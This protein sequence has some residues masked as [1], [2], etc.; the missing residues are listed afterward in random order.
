MPRRLLKP[1]KS[2]ECN[3]Q[4]PQARIRQTTADRPAVALTRENVRL[5]DDEHQN[6]SC[7][8]TK[9]R[10]P[11]RMSPL[12]RL[13]HRFSRPEI[14]PLESVQT[15]SVAFDRATFAAKHHQKGWLED[16]CCRELVPCFR[17][18]ENTT[19]SILWNFANF[20]RKLCLDC[21]GCGKIRSDVAPRTR[22]P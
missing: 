2:C 22:R 8:T 7:K 21:R 4:E 1:R 15:Y 18:R 12:S 19:H 5:S 17:D 3:Y 20:R 9:P 6:V 16:H 14:I 13:T 10:S 11:R